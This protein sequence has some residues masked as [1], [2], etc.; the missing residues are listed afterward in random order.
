MSVVQVRI[1]NCCQETAFMVRFFGRVGGSGS[2]CQLLHEKMMIKGRQLLC[3]WF[4]FGL[5]IAASETGI[6]FY[7]A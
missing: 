1:V 2:D 7:L 3:R 4:R 5:S 6:P